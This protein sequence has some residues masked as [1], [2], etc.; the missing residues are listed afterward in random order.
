M[1]L[2]KNASVYA[3]E[4]KGVKDI[5]TGGGH[6]LCIDRDLNINAP[7]LNVVDL[8]G[9]IIIPGLIDSHIHIAG[10]GGEGGPA[11]RTRELEMMKILSSGITSVVGCLGTDGITRTVASV[12]MKAKAF[13]QS[14]MSAWIY[15]G[16]YQVPPPTITGDISKDIALIDEVIGVGE[17]ALGDHRS[18]IPGKAEFARL[19]QQARLGGLISNKSGV[20]NIHLGDSG[21]P[22]DFLTGIVREFQISYY[23]MIPTH[24]NRSR[25][26]FDNAKKYGLKGNVD[27]TTSSYEFYKDIEIKP[28]EAYF[29]LIDA[30]VDPEMITMSSD[31]GGSLPVFNENDEFVRSSSGDPMSLIREVKDIFGNSLGTNEMVGSALKTVTLNI[32]E[33]LKL[34]GKG[35]VKEGNDA[36]LVILDPHLEIE[37]VMA[38]GVFKTGKE[39]LLN[40]IN[41]S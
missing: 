10:A 1:I 11:S 33:K 22:F 18:S 30:G 40:K 14:G 28:S 39:D 29:E 26:V 4:F 35:E 37:S 25:K 23:S 41:K 38:N 5:L 13:R 6:I 36:D 31:S 8:R 32:A 19:V 2:L 7:G 16:S 9:R 12:L 21:D 17:V 20:V 24:C 3:P 15:T 27:L 34:E